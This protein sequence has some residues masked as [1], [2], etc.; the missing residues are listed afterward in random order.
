MKKKS[1]AK[2]TMVFL[3]ILSLVPLLPLQARAASF[4]VISEFTFPPKVNYNPL[5][6]Q[7]MTGLG[8]TAL[9]L[10]L[11]A[12]H[13]YKGLFFPALGKDIKVNPEEGYLEVT[14]WSDNYWWDGENLSPFTAKDVWTYYM[15]QWKIF[16][17]FIPWL[18]DIK[19]IDDY[20]IR[21]YFN[22]TE[23]KLKAT[24]VDDPSRTFEYSYKSNLYYQGFFR[25]SSRRSA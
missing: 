14:L 12:F 16:R 7:S 9:T 24:A 25:H 8:Y 15:I 1:L 2:A 4:S 3:V 20:T 18:L 13:P 17:N 23:F 21:F 6:P 22:A 19:I 10:P 11:F 5:A